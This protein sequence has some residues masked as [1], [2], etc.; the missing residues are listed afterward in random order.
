MFNYV[1]KIFKFE[2]GDN[3]TNKLDL[4]LVLFSCISFYFLQI[5][6]STKCRLKGFLLTE[7]KAGNENKYFTVM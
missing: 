7:K 5:L 1:T 4:T 2:V 3:N 6:T